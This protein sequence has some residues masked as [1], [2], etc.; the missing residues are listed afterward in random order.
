MPS[1]L[2]NK[3]R[4]NFSLECAGVAA[5]GAASYWWLY[6]RPSNVRGLPAAAP[7]RRKLRTSAGSTKVTIRDCLFRKN[8]K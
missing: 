6:L 7:Q 1:K 2:G 5:V 4:S 3:S 8:Q